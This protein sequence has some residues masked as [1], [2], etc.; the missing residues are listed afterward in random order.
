LSSLITET[1]TRTRLHAKPRR[2]HDRAMADEIDLSFLAEQGKR[3][4]AELQDMREQTK[5]IPQLAKDVS[6]LQVAVAALSVDLKGTKKTVEQI[7]E[8]QQNHGYRLNAIDGRLALIEKHT[9][10]VK[11]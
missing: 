7:H 5:L 2:E 1:L 4:L 11:A 10:M 9:G 3:I 6:E 8:T